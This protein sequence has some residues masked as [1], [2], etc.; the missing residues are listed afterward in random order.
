MYYVDLET[1]VLYE[2]KGQRKRVPTGHCNVH[3][4][5]IGYK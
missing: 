4:T 1:F 2:G 5:P 3:S